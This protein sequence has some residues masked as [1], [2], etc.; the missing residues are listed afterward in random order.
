MQHRDVD[1]LYSENGIVSCEGAGEVYFQS[2]GVGYPVN[3]TRRVPAMAQ[4]SR[5]FGLTTPISRGPKITIHPMIER[6]LELSE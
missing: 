3:G 2:G 5:R 1:G 4:T 6:G